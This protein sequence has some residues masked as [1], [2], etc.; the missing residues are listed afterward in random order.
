ML[1]IVVVDNPIIVKNNL[2]RKKQGKI[3]LIGS[4]SNFIIC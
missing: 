3:W 1:G 2:L 4:G